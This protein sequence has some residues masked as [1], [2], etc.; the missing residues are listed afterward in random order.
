MII[1]RRSQG[2]QQMVAQGLSGQ[3]ADDGESR[4]GDDKSSAGEHPDETGHED[5]EQELNWNRLQQE[6][7]ARHRGHQ[8]NDLTKRGDCD[9]S[10]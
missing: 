5:T 10:L 2:T 1:T 6:H 7:E 4:V 8:T 3:C 9:E